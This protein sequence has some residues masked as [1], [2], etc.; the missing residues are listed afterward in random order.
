MENNR[1]Y[2]IR[3]AE[4]ERSAATD[5]Q[6]VKVRAVHEALAERYNELAQAA[7]SAEQASNEN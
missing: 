6:D 3:R 5:A 2:F 1:S 4:Q 7:G